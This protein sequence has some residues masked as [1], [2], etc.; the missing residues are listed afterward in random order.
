VDCEL[1]TEFEEEHLSAIV[2]KLKELNDP[3][4]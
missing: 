4:R 2:E 3:L 1:L